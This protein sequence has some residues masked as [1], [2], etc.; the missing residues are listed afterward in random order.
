MQNQAAWP[1]RHTMVQGQTSMERMHRSMS[2]RRE[3]P[4]IMCDSAT[5]FWP[6][7]ECIEARCSLVADHDGPHFDEHLETHW[8]DNG[9]WV[10]G[11]I[12][13]HGPQGN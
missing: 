4:C 9:D 1:V 6:E 2:N 7:E 10:P 8:D 12:T 13:W 5:V 3:T 11:N